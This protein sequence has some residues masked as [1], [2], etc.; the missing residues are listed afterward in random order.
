[1]SDSYTQGNSLTRNTAQNSVWG[2][3]RNLQLIPK[4]EVS[5][6]DEGPDLVA[7]KVSCSQVYVPDL[8]LVWDDKQQGYKVYL[9]V[10]RSEG[11]CKESAGYAIAVVKNGLAASV[12]VMVYQFFHK[13]RANSKTEAA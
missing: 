9:H 3:V 7:I 10:A 11:S 13:Y 2:V 8:M 1:M 4:V 12:L 6:K 5:R